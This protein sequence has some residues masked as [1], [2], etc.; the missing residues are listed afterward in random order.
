MKLI[1]ANL[2]E[3][4]LDH[5]ADDNLSGKVSSTDAIKGNICLPL[6]IIGR[7]SISKAAGGTTQQCTIGTGQD[8]NIVNQLILHR[9]Q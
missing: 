8:I 2:D 4:Q 6:L 1:D 9:L 5:L 3:V 7:N